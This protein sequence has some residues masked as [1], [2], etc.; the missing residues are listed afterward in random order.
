MNSHD[1]KR[2][3][4]AVDLAEPTGKVLETAALLARALDAA[5]ELVHVREP[6]LTALPGGVLMTRAQEEA[7]T[8]WI[9]RSLAAATEALS[10]RGVPSIATSVDGFPE[11][12]IVEHARKVGADLLVVGSHGR[13]GL[14]HALLG[15]VAERVLQRA[16]CPVVV[17]PVGRN[18]GAAS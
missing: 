16:P 15:S 4:V 3:L 7:V 10:D 1:R 14:A 5:I 8:E 18:A 17:V 2:V 13:K 11:S 9:D 12:R 6:F